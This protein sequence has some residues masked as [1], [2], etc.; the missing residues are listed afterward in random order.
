MVWLTESDR[1]SGIKRRLSYAYDR[2]DNLI[3]RRDD[4]L[5]QPRIRSYRYDRR[6]NLTHY[7]DEEGGTARIFYDGNGRVRKLVRPEQYDSVLD[8]GPGTCYQYNHMGKVTAVIN[9]LGQTE[10]ENEY[11]PE[12]NLIGSADG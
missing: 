1:E 4:S 7:V 10:Q 6:D 12:G 3:G 11:D 5:E 2:A 9:A 8:D